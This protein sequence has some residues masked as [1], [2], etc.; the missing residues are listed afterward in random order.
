MMGIF[1]FVHIDENTAFSQ[2][3]SFLEQKN[4]PFIASGSQLTRFL[5][6]GELEEQERRK[7]ICEKNSP[8]TAQ[9]LHRPNSRSFQEAVENLPLYE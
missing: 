8:T 1:L 5:W 4:E 3:S 7:M 9:I 6:K 2:K